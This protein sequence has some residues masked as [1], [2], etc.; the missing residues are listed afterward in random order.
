M[1]A[2]PPFSRDLTVW[3]LR[4]LLPNLAADGTLIEGSRDSHP[5]AGGSE[6]DLP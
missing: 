4:L 6:S 3:A 2:L 1:P 5:S